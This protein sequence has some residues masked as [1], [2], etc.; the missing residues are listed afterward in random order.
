VNSQ[1]TRHSAASLS[2]DLMVTGIETALEIIAA[3]D[4]LSG[5]KRS[6]KRRTR[7]GSGSAT[8]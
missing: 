5:E 7:I 8:L 2:L 3:A 6:S 1:A 4:G